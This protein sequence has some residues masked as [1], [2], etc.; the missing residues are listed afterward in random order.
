MPGLQFLMS[1]AVRGIPGP[2]GNASSDIVDY[3]LSYGPLG[4]GLVAIIS[5]VLVPFWVM[6]DER[7]AHAAELARMKEDWEA[8][9]ADW[10]AE[11]QRLIADKER[12]EVRVT[13]AIRDKDEALRLVTDKAIPM[14]TMFTATAQ[15]LIPLLQGQV[16]ESRRGRSHGG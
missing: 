16:Q 11:R 4:L 1:L 3:V 13:E 7:V 9:Q 8:K 10:D 15:S 5:K 14:L 6:K 12:A 2:V